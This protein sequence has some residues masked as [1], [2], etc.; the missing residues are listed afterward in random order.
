MTFFAIAS[1]SEQPE[2][3]II[4]WSVREVKI[5]CETEKTHHLV[6]YIPWQYS[7]RVS[8]KIETFDRENMLVKTGSGRIYHL[9]GEPG[10]TRDGDYV[11]D[12]WAMI[13]D[14]KNEVDVTDQY[15]DFQI[16]Q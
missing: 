9:K 16:S 5:S 3:N 1:I 2:E 15:F 8:S 14:A 4:H 6:G 10:M 12:R 13:N 11:W 7:G